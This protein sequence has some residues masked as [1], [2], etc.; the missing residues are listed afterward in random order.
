MEEIEA[1]C[2]KLEE[3]KNLKAFCQDLEL[4]V[5]QLKGMVQESK[6]NTLQ[7]PFRLESIKEKPNLVTY[8]LI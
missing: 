3:V 7:L 2:Q 4:E 5:E 8:S 1:K 6:D